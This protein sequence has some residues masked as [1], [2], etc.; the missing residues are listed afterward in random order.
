MIEA[1]CDCC[2]NSLSSMGAILLSPSQG[3]GTCQKFHICTSCW[4]V[5]SKLVR[6]APMVPEYVRSNDSVV[7]ESAVNGHM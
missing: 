5:I 7:M 3:N 4:P 6:R 1:K 2:G